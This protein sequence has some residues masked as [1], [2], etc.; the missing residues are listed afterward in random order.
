[1]KIR[2]LA[3]VFILMVLNGWS[4]TPSHSAG[5]VPDPPFAGERIVVHLNSTFFLTGETL[6]FKV[7]CFEGSKPFKLSG[8][9]SIA[10]LELIGADQKPVAQ[11]KVTM[12]NGLGSGDYFFPGY[13]AS[14]NYTLIAYTKWMRN[15][16]SDR[17]Y[18]ANIKLI[19]PQ[20]RLPLADGDLPIGGSGDSLSYQKKAAGMGDQLLSIKTDRKEYG[21][22]QPVS[23]QLDNRDS[24]ETFLT[25]NVRAMDESLHRN[26]PCSHQEALLSSTPFSITYLPDVR[27]EL[28]S[29]TL[30]DKASGNALAGTLVT[31]SSPSKN[32]EFKISAT[33]SYGRFYFNVDAITSEYFLLKAVENQAN[34]AVVMKTSDEFLGRYDGFVPAALKIEQWMQRIID[35]RYLSA[36]VE[37]VFYSVKKDSIPGRE[38]HR[39]YITPEKIYN[40][41]DFTRFPTMDDVFREIVPEVVVKVRDGIYS[42]LMINHTTG[43][44]F[45][46]APLVVIDGIPVTDANKVM[47]YDPSFIKTISLI[48][49]R[50]YY[51]PLEAEGVVSIETFDGDARGL[52]VDDMVRVSYVPPQPEKIYYFP[53][54]VAGNSLAR[55]PD[56]R[57]QLY[58]NPQLTIK[59]FSINTLTFFTGDLPGKYFVEVVGVSAGGT[60]VYRSEHFEVR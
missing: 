28:I 60:R 38:G 25:V 23:L 2:F 41:D 37:N 22:R 45:T 5:K 29:G 9:S 10:Y 49:S 26:E 15:F 21:L 19:N 56:Y 34:Q 4:Q 13:M 36:Q 33:D 42:L 6:F 18:S 27:G 50:Y 16:P 40:L 39:F 51:G 35:K 46:K 53:Q 52:Q 24:T 3:G 32:F 14:G 55:I 30:Y 59:K 1:M 48:R 12:K 43:Y 58:W 11:M 17:F 57:T 54:Y 47:S 7:Y 8:L 20:M 31:L 44:R